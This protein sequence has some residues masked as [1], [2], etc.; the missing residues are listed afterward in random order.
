M[1][2]WFVRGIYVLLVSLVHFTNNNHS[3]Q[4]IHSN[5]NVVYSTL[6]I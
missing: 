4:K 6:N 2:Y 5:I 1:M 3:Q